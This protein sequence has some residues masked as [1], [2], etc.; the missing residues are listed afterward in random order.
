MPSPLSSPSL[1][2]LS[3]SLQLN[4]AERSEALRLLDR[5][6]SEQLLRRAERGITVCLD[7]VPAVKVNS[8]PKRYA[9]KVK[10]A[11]LQNLVAQQCA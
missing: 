2:S 7:G 9:E 8:L 4:Y 10:T 11:V 6:R 1:L 3:P 5:E